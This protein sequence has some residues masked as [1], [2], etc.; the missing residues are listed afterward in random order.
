MGKLF[1]TYTNLDFLGKVV[2]FLE[3]L[4]LPN[5]RLVDHNF[6]PSGIEDLKQK[7]WCS[8]NISPWETSR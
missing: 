1:K 4:F 6:R 2:P 7:W 8:P 5:Y 3:D